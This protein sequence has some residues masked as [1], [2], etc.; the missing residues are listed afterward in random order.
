MNKIVL[1]ESPLRTA[2]LMTVSAIAGGLL[3]SISFTPQYFSLSRL[4]SPFIPEDIAASPTKLHNHSFIPEEALQKVAEAQKVRVLCWVLT[5]PA[6]H[7]TKSV[8]VKAT[9]G[10]H[11]DKLIFMSTKNDPKLGAIDLGVPEGRNELWAKTKAAFTYVYKNH[12]N[13]YD[14]FFKADADTYTIM[15]NMR[16]MLSIYDPNFPIYFGSRFR[17]FTKKGYM[18]GG[19]G[20][21]LSREAVKQ[22]VEV[23]L[24]NKT[25]CSPSITGIEDLEMGICLN[26]IG[27]LGGDSRDGKGRGRFFPGTLTSYLFNELHFSLLDY[28]YYNL[29]TGLNCCSDSAV[30]FHNID[31]RKMYEMEYLLYHLRPHGVC[32]KHPIP[33]PLPPDT[34]SVP[35]QVLKMRGVTATVGAAQRGINTY[36]P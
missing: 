15:E 6:T 11:C 35:S 31:I 27:V 12:L 19:A 1:R 33:A 14:W 13:D 10:S 7:Y 2:M 32:P 9:W 24:P 26:N 23:S 36:K 8:H 18:S 21:V 20:Y 22:F 4:R 5:H 29:N 17:L 3:S 30:S 34:D 28:A 25:L 16:Y